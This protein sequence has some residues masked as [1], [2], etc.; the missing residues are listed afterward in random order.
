MTIGMPAS[1]PV[2]R[3]GRHRRPEQGA[4]FMEYTSLLAG[5]VFGDRPGCVDAG[6]AA[7]LRGANDDLPDAQRRRLLPLLG[8][9]IGLA[10]LPPPRAPGR[11]APRRARHGSRREV[12]RYRAQVAALRESVA[13]RFLSALG[14]SPEEA[15]RRWPGCGREVPWLFWSGLSRPAPPR[16]AEERADR[17]VERLVLLNGWC[18]CTRATSGPCRSWVSPGS[19]AGGERSHPQRMRRTRGRC[20][21][22]TAST[23]RRTARAAGVAVLLCGGRC[24][25]HDRTGSRSE[26]AGRAAGAGAWPAPGPCAGCVLHGV[27]VPARG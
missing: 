23:G 22:L 15:E 13:E 27:H 25:C 11:R 17:I 9:S 18:C 21:T 6:L 3:R 2:L 1:L 14:S 24:R 4:C 26:R 8:R 12:A 5:E 20:T 16:S 19:R 10:V 7:V